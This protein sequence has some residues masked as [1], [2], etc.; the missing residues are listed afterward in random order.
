[1]VFTGVGGVGRGLAMRR[2][3]QGKTMTLGGG[4]A[5]GAPLASVALL[6]APVAAPQHDH[7][8]ARWCGGKS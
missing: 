7:G 8:I 2:Q 5:C 6:A 1:M 4:G 3:T